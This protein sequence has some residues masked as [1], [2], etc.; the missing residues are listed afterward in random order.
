MSEKPIRECEAEALRLNK[1]GYSNSAI[2]QHIGVHRNT[3]RKWLKKHGVDPKMNGSVADGKVLN[4]L[5]HNTKIKDE[6]ID[7]DKDQLKEDI[8]EHFNETMSSALVEERFRASK[9]EDVTLNEIAEAQNTPADKY[10]HYVAAAGIKLLRDSMKGIRAPRTIR[11]MS[12]LDQLIRRNLGLNAKT[13]GGSSKMQIDI[14]ILNN[15]KADKGGGA[16][17]QK[18]TIDAET[19]KE[20]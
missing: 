17:R 19:G 15:S 4:N 18:K 2:G 6:H 20:I 8:E 1:E 3:I 13:G 10:Q 7:S 16:I 14:S 9:E 11:E 12:E 5:I